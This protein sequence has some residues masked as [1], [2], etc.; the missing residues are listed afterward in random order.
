MSNL[1]LYNHLTPRARLERQLRSYYTHQQN[2]NHK[3]QGYVKLETGEAANYACNTFR[4]TALSA[5][6]DVTIDNTN[7]IA[8]PSH[9]THSGANRQYRNNRQTSKTNKSSA[10]MLHYMAPADRR[11]A[12]LI[13]NITGDS[14]YRFRLA[15]DMHHLSQYTSNNYNNIICGGSGSNRINA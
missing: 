1:H 6:N 14:R 7:N 10:D 13:F 8:H 3:R 12:N 4:R 11:A 15:T 9:S 5:E 2:Y